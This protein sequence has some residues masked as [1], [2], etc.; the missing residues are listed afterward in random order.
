M[1]AEKRILRRYSA[2]EAQEIFRRGV[3]CLELGAL[4]RPKPLFTYRF[5]VLGDG[6]TQTMN[7]KFP[8]TN[9]QSSLCGGGLERPAWSCT[10]SETVQLGTEPAQPTDLRNTPNC[11]N[12]QGAELQ[13][14]WAD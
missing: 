14:G 7:D 12:A 11:V 9:K 1:P 5:I 10:K 13:R 4:G 2:Q 8:E 3:A 6:K